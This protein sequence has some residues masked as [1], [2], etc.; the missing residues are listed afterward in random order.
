MKETVRLAWRVGAGYWKRPVAPLSVNLVLTQRCDLRCRYCGVWRAPPPE[1]DTGSWLSVIDEMAATGVLRLS[2][3][4]GEPSLR[5]DWQ[6]IAHHARRRGLHVDLLT[7]G[8]PENRLLEITAAERLVVSLDGCE[9]SHEAMRGRGSHSLAWRT[10]EAG[11]RMGLPVW[12]TTVVTAQTTM[13]EIALMI[14]QGR[15]LGVKMSF[16]P[17]MEQTFA[18]PSLKALMPEAARWQ[19]ILSFLVRER[20]KRGSPLAMSSALLEFYR[21]HWGRSV[22]PRSG[23]WHAGVL[24]CRAGRFFAAVTPDGRLAPCVHRLDMAQEKIAAQGFSAAWQRLRLP[25]CGGCWCDSFIEANLAFAGSP[26]ALCQ[27]FKTWRETRSRSA[28]QPSP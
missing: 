17:V 8:L 13:A 1:L 3:T 28:R 9:K 19:E 25:D 4:G 22:K 18:S 14:E 16:L 7:H 15:R 21:R 27:V 12:T 5:E 10:I 20:R 24:P 23:A 11:R 2:L 6:E 26:S